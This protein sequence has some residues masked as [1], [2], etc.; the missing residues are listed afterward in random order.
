MD[1]D[2]DVKL[3]PQKEKE[4]AKSP[5][6]TESTQRRALSQR[7]IPEMPM[8]SEPELELSISNSKRYQSHSKGSDRHLHE[9]VQAVLPSVQRQGLE[10]AATNTPKSD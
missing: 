8:I 6:G 3:I 2:S 1:L 4:R 5:S 9:P 10:N 7:Q